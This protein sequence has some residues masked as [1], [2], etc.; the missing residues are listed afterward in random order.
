MRIPDTDDPIALFG[1][2]YDEAL[3]CGLKNPTAVT[4]ATA[5]E[6]ARPSARMVLL[7]GFDAAGF[8]FYT[9][10]ESRKGDQLTTNGHAALCFYWPPLDRQVRVEGPVT[11]VSDTESDAYFATRPRQAQIGAWASDQSRPLAGRFDLEK[12]V[13]RF[14]LKFAIGEVPRPPHW[15]GFRVAPELIEFWHEGAFRLHD[16]LIFIREGDGWRTERQF[17]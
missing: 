10:N 9:N 8:V 14:A 12:R 3:N 2:W 4:L 11:G 1:E 16:R 7:K 13:A 17:P 5:D 15:S 6:Q